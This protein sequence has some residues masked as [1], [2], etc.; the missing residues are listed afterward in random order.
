[1]DPIR[2]AFNKVREELDSLHSEISDIK[3]N[4]SITQEEVAK[5]SEILIEMSKN[6]TRMN[7]RINKSKIHESMFQPPTQNS[8]P[9]QTY[10]PAQKPKKQ[11]IPTENPTQNLV[12]THNS[13]LKPLKEPNLTVSSGNSGV[14]TDRQT[15]Q[16]TDKIS[17]NPLR[18]PFEISS[19]NPLSSLQNPL[20]KSS[21]SPQGEVFTSSS[22]NKAKETKERK[23]NDIDNAARIL[24]SLDGIKKEI[25]LKFKRLTSQ[26]M[27]VFSM[28]Y[29]LEEETGDVDYKALATKLNL[30]ESSV[31]DYVGRILSKGIPVDKNKINNKTIKLSI[32]Q[33][34]K[35]IASLPT[36][37]Q[38]RDL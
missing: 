15:D 2:D 21:E 19:S 31:R 29:L 37:L 16:Q 6:M 34:L 13:P 12:P 18:N 9:L 4:L 10:L 8:N 22:P 36:I 14:P 28:I 1:M 23:E 38:L 35:K 33:N 25:R 7:T 5:F 17:E 30:T 27:A 32:P 11:A 24:D 26:E 3:Q 20:K